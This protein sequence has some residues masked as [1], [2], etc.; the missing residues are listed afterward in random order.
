[1]GTWNDGFATCKPFRWT[2]VVKGS[3]LAVQLHITRI[4]ILWLEIGIQ[5]GTGNLQI[6]GRNTHGLFRL[7]S[8]H[9][10]SSTWRLWSR[11]ANLTN[12]S[13]LRIVDHMDGW[14]IPASHNT[15]ST[16]TTTHNDIYLIR[17]RHFKFFFCF[18]YEIQWGSHKYQIL[19]WGFRGMASFSTSTLKFLE[20]SHNDMHVPRLQPTSKEGNYI[21]LTH[22]H[23]SKGCDSM[24]DWFVWRLFC[25]AM[26][27]LYVERIFQIIPKQSQVLA[28]TEWSN[29]YPSS[30]MSATL[31]DP[32]WET[33]LLGITVLQKRTA[34]ISRHPRLWWPL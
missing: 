30:W 15:S 29:Y 31:P 14:L 24:F 21:C 9:S 8:P 26:C 1:M 13:F 20:T 25:I 18:S 16:S 4:W 17:N 28:R 23:R 10:M 12:V 34:G 32:N 3:S 2:R 27:G 11:F 33:W 6:P 19:S 5:R 22:L 7:L